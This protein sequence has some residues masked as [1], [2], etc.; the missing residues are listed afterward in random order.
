MVERTHY[1]LLDRVD[2]LEGLVC[3]QMAELKDKDQR[4]AELGRLSVHCDRC[5]G[6]YAQ[7][8]V[9]VGCNCE[10]VARIEED[11]R[12]LSDKCAEDDKRKT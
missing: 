6:D 3:K 1:E 4:I 8:G 7:T 10:L 11:G 9:E 12:S 2:I 5:G